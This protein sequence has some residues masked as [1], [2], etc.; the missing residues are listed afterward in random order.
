MRLF[1]LGVL[2]LVAATAAVFLWPSGSEEPPIGASET[3]ASWSPGNGSTPREDRG[4]SAEMPAPAA[5]NAGPATGTDPT[6]VVVEALTAERPT[7]LSPPAMT[8]A[9]GALIDEAP[10]EHKAATEAVQIP[11]PE[12]EAIAVNSE[13]EGPGT[14]PTGEEVTREP[15]EAAATEPAEPRIEEVKAAEAKT[16]E[17]ETV[18]PETQESETES[19]GAAPGS[20]PEAE[21]IAAADP[22]PVDPEI[23]A[24]TPAATPAPPA[25]ETAPPA[26]QETETGLLLAGRWNVPGRGT[27]E[28]PFVLNWDML[29]AV[30]REYEPRLG[31]DT[32]PE[33]VAALN[34]KRVAIEGYALLPIGGGSMSE[35][36]V[37]MN[38]WDGCCI[39]VPPSPYDAIEVR[40]KDRLA[41]TATQTFGQG[42]AVAYGRLTGTFQVDAYIVQGWLLGLY[43]LNDAKAEL[44]GPAGAP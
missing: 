11:P 2:V 18:E 1:W 32:V 40:L 13:G 34:G 33:W 42:G 27:D 19:N 38:Q 8:P 6:P 26:V 3:P 39:G 16:E 29:V 28:S 5:E 30:Q 7:E 25:R 23:A 44:F 41:P 17:P 15:V 20:S 21:P 43:L 12:P 10:A 22:A 4:P 9:P 36:L 24:P 35:L 31:K 37:M 14:V